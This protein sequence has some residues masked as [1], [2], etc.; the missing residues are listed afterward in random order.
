M[1]SE[2]LALERR[3][4]D[5]ETG[6]LRLDPGM[7]KNG[8]AR[9]VYLT[10]DVKAALAAQLG[11]VDTLQK[12]LGRVIPYLFPH[13]EGKHRGQP[14]REF[15]KAWAS[16]CTAAGVP[17]MLKHDFRRTAVR[18]MERSGVPR[19]VATKLTGHKTEAVYR[20]YAIVSDSDLREASLRLTGTFSGT[21][22]GARLTCVL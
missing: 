20:R 4:L 6:T 12:K 19:S 21:S 9:A 3:H 10:G 15:R 16:A 22:G 7:T 1:R 11:R 8:D 18:N 13:A 14:R 17:G 2:V 5:I